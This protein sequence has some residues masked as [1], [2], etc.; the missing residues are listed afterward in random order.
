MFGN[1]VSGNL[2]SYDSPKQD[3]QTVSNMTFL[4]SASDQLRQ[5]Y[6]YIVLNSRILVE[7]FDSLQPLKNACIQHMPHK[8]TEEM[9]KKSI[10]QQ[11][12]CINENACFFFVCLFNYIFEAVYILVYRFFFF[13]LFLFG[14]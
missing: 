8:Y 7:Y 6:N 13:S 5:R 4:P 9:S 2:L 10:N 11:I 14:L 1:R 3:L 12:A